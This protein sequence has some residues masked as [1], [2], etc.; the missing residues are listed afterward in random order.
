MASQWS[1]S[2]DF[3]RTNRVFLGRGGCRPL[4]VPFAALKTPAFE[5]PLSIFLVKIGKIPNGCC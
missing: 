5:R 4:P 3:C 2:M 1:M